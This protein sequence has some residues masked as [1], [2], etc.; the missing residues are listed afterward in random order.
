MWQRS[1]EKRLPYPGIA[2]SPVYIRY[3]FVMQLKSNSCKNKKR[4]CLNTTS[5]ES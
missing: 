4:L 5:F 3:I 1:L 2:A